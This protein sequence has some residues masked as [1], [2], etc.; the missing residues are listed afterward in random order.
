MSAKLLLLM[1]E[2]SQAD[3]ELILRALRNGGYDIHHERVYTSDALKDALARKPW[4]IILSDYSM[5]SFTGLAALSIVRETNL[6]LPFILVSGTVGEER[7]VQAMRAGAQDYVLKGNLTRLAPAVA[8]ELQE[9]RR[10]R[11]ERAHERERLENAERIK[12]FRRFFS[13]HIA[14]LI[15]SKNIDDP[16]K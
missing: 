12:Q 15:A 16:F 7:A 11:E 3:A 9:A 2:D 6:D 10:R 4:H 8:R 14:D 5:P 1:I 13:P